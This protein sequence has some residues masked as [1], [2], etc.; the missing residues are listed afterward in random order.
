MVEIREVV[1]LKLARHQLVPLV[2]EFRRRSVAR[3]HDPSSA[4]R[5]ARRIHE[6]IKDVESD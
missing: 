5:S 4:L 1:Y 3:K 6:F 2:G